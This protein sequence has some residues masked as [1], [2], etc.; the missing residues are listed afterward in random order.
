MRRAALA[1]A[2]VCTFLALSA[3]LTLGVGAARAA[4][5][6]IGNDAGDV[7]SEVAAATRQLHLAS[8]PAELLVE[9]D[10]LVFDYER[11]ELAYSGDV[12][13]AQGGVHM[14]SENLTIAFEPQ[15]TGSLRSIRASGNVLI[16]HKNTK[17]TG[18]LAIYDPTASTITLTGEARLGAGPNT[19][20]GER[21]IVYLDEGRAIV[22]GG[23]ADGAQSA[24]APAPEAGSAGPSDA[25]EKKPSGRVRAVI[26]PGTLGSEDLL[27]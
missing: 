5:V 23:A 13:V 15:R 19:L 27:D 3:P 21:V 26:D 2:A 11:G 18:N 20:E 7:I 14:R 25:V 16:T 8:V 17:A 6:V 12:R 24:T 4:D 9:S 10:T 22:E 1:G